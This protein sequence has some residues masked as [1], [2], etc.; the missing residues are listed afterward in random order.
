MKNKMS[1][2][3]FFVLIGLIFAI[4][5]AYGLRLMNIQIVN[6]DKYKDRLP[7]LYTR[8]QR[9]KAARGEIFDRNGVPLAINTIGYDLTINKAYFPSGSENEII[10]RLVSILSQAGEEWNDTL[11]ITETAPFE[12]VEGR[13][14]AVSKLKKYL[15]IEQYATVEDAVYWLKDKYGLEEATDEEF[16]AI[17]G[18][19]YEMYLRD[20]SMKTPFVFASD[21]SMDTVTKISE[22]SSLLQGAVIEETTVRE[23]VAGDIAPHLVGII[24]PLY[25]E[26]LEGLPDDYSLNDY[27]GKIGVEKTYED[28]LRGEDGEMTVY[29]DGTG[30]V[31][32]TEV[33]TH[34]TPGNSVYLTIDANLQRAVQDSLATHIEYLKQQEDTDHGKDV[35]A[36]SVVVMDVASGELL[37]SANYPTYNLSTYY[38]DYSTLIK[39]ENNPYYNRAFSGIYAPGSTYKPSVSIAA[40][41]ENLIT[42]STTVTCTG[43]YYHFPAYQPTCMGVHSATNVLNALKVSCNVFFYDVGRQLG[44]E[45]VN[46][47]SSLLGLGQ[48]TGVELP[49]R[50]GRLAGP[51]YRESIGLDW[52]AGDILQASIG[53]SDNAFTPLQL[54]NYA[55]ALANS[56]KRMDVNVIKKITSYNNEETFYEA[57]PEVVVDLADYGVGESALST[58]K[59]G[60]LLATAGTAGAPLRNY[61]IKIASKTGTPETGSSLNAAFI[62]Y[63][64]A[65]DPQIAISIILENAG[66]GYNA[67]QIARYI[68]DYYFFGITPPALDQESE[69]N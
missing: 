36:G 19:R 16:R 69:K 66:H 29:L 68:L 22:N 48:A 59:E 38:E 41:S 31:I 57:V 5:F 13:E 35:T 11:P 45:R 10:L 27:I 46:R 42:A 67:T 49:E 55:A 39:D 56:G 52:F 44:I 60:M 3:R 20:F 12:F 61:P 54:A 14:S 25:P 37:A 53:Q 9:L 15:N 30:K 2:S 65:D 62:C 33:T 51:E 21:I 7:S 50:T 23:Y 58:V 26:D 28:E 32:S 40:L 18:V 6:A 47:Y 8:T 64:P 43:K 17:A 24:G 4:M 63:A 34:P 1:V